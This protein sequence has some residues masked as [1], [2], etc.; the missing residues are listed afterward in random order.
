MC[1]GQEVAIIGGGNS[2]G[3]AAIFMAGRSKHVH[4]L[5]RRDGLAETMSDYLIKR[6]D[7]HPG[8]TLHSNTEVAAL[9]GETRVDSMI[10]RCR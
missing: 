3:Q 7:A 2:A 8:I 9:E 5:V 10:W 1:D 4:I 6:I